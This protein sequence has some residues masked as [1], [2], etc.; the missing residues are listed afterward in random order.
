[1]THAALTAAVRWSL[2]HDFKRDVYPPVKPKP[3]PKS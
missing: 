3:A 1:M 2:D